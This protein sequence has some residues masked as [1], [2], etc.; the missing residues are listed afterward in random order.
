MDIN[1]HYWDSVISV[2]TI[3][4][5]VKLLEIAHRMVYNTS[6][7][8]LVLMTEIETYMIWIECRD[9]KYKTK[10]CVK[11]S[12]FCYGNP[13]TPETITLNA[14]KPHREAFSMLNL[15]T[16]GFQRY[17][18]LAARNFFEVRPL[19]MLWRLHYWIKLFGQNRTL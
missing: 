12:Q 4:W 3:F 10:F 15:R 6:L 16:R 2:I 5:Y 19:L 18:I 17:I 14:Q 9:V 11:W 7:L 1:I 8:Y 13:F